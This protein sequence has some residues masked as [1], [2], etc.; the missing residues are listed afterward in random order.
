M[1]KKTIMALLMIAAIFISP[2]AAKQYAYSPVRFTVA[3]VIQF[4]VTLAGA[5]SGN[6][7]TENVASNATEEIWF[8]ASTTDTKFIEPCRAPGTNCQSRFA[9]PIAIFKNTGTAAFNI[10][11]Q[12]NNT[13]DSSIV[14]W[15]N[16]SNASTGGCANSVGANN[17]VLTRTTAFNFTMNLCVGNSTNLWLFANFTGTPVGT[18]TNYLNYT[19]D[20]T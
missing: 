17:T 18:I 4:T 3:T 20:T 15:A 6:I 8:N 7:S 16:I 13:Q 1:N 9:T 14:L 10:S 5:A 19:S 2:I 11:I 12:L